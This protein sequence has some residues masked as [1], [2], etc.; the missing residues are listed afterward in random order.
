[1]KLVEM[2][3]QDHPKR[4]IRTIYYKEYPHGKCATDKSALATI[5]KAMVQNE[6][7]V[8]NSDSVKNTYNHI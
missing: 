1:M 8:H 4:M 6:L 7:G 5:H 3:L 2:H